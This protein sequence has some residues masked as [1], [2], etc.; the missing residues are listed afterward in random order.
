M[1][2]EEFDSIRLF[3]QSHDLLHRVFHHGVAVEEQV[4]EHGRCLSA[5]QVLHIVD[6]MI[7]Q[8]MQ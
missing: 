2:L 3:Q 8:R 1:D 6:Q 4:V 7:G 5:I